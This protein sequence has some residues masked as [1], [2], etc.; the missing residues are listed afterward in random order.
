MASY[1]FPPPFLG[2]VPAGRR[3]KVSSPGDRV[4]PPPSAARPPPPEAVEERVSAI[5]PHASTLILLESVSERLKPSD[6]APS[7]ASNVYSCATYNNFRPRRASQHAE[8]IV[9]VGEADAAILDG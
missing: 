5:S 9:Y 1:F 2:E 6:A 7:Q 3:G 8:L 4:M